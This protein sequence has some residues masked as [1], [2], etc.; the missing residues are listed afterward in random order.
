MVILDIKIRNIQQ[1]FHCQVVTISNQQI[2]EIERVFHETY[3]HEYTYRLDM[4]V[5]MV[6]IHVVATSEVGKLTMKEMSSTGTL[7]SRS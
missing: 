1:R 4:P 2:V 3:E 7:R 5:E 6:G